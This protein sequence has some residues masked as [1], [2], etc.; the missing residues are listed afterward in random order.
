MENNTGFIQQ[1]VTNKE[2][3]GCFHQVYLNLLS[4]SICTL[5]LPI[6]PA[7]SVHLNQ[8]RWAFS[9][10]E[11][12]RYCITLYILV[13]ALQFVLWWALTIRL[14]WREQE[15]QKAYSVLDLTCSCPPLHT[16]T[17][18]VISIFLP[19][20]FIHKCSLAFLISI[21]NR[22]TCLMVVDYSQP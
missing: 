3:L 19:D 1:K 17:L 2:F 8:N 7:I 15:K 22:Y 16:Q 5:F 12:C 21:I 18:S 14:W 20:I 11:P 4:F 9:P 13:H 6:L 10:Q